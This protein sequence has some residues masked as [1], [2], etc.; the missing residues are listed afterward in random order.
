MKRYS[1]SNWTQVSGENVFYWKHIPNSSLQKNVAAIIVG[2]IGP[3]YMHCHRTVKWLAIELANSGIQTIRYDPVGM[4]NSTGD[5]LQTDIFNHWLNSVVVL[6]E[7]LLDSEEVDDVVLIGMR[8]GCLVLHEYLQTNPVNSAVYWFPY[9]NGKSYLRDLGLIDKLMKNDFKH[10]AY[11][12]GGGYPVS[13]DCQKRL[14]S[15]NIA[16]KESNILGTALLIE[17]SDLFPNKK[18]IAQMSSS[19]KLTTLSLDG[20]SEMTRQASLSKVPEQNISEIIKWFD[21]LDQSRVGLE[22]SHKNDIQE[23]SIVTTKHYSEKVLEI[24]SDSRLFGI[25]CEPVEKQTNSVLLLVNAGSAHQV[26]P[27]R[28]NV[29]IARELAVEGVSSFRFDL[30]HLG[31][32]QTTSP[33]QSN[34]P[35]L[36]SS[37]EDMQNVINHFSINSDAEIVLAGVCSGAHNFFQAINFQIMPKVKHLVMIN[38]LT[39]YWQEGQSIIGL[40]GNEEIAND[41]YYK[42]QMF[43]LKKWIILMTSPRKIIVILSHLFKV[44]KNKFKQVLLKF[45]LGRKSKLDKDLFKICENNIKISFL[46][47]DSDPGLEILKKEAPFVVKRKDTSNDFIVREIKHADHTFS[48]IQSRRALYQELKQ[49]LAVH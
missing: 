6:R 45:G 15:I 36:K 41:K 29:D 10:D 21:G 1:Q 14:S 19:C 35:Y 22:S 31:D 28:I 11:I 5:L 8:S 3:E 40:D 16:Q 37:M 46:F 39:F 33:V 42:Q 49:I 17:D 38:P 9:V 48:N 34:N 44:I 24:S 12:E 43:S 7:L 25:F 23:E 26:G 18:L 47:S 20:L 13:S 30:S 32:S 4:G 27:N 2:P